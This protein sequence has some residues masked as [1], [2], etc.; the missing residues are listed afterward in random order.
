MT[1]EEL[2]QALLEGEEVT[3]PSREGTGNGQTELSYTLSTM[4]TAETHGDPL[5]FGEEEARC[6]SRPV[7]VLPPG[8]SAGPPVSHLSGEG[9]SESPRAVLPGLALGIGVR[10]KAQGMACVQWGPACVGVAWRWA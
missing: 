6:A 7:A 2:S 5:S 9:R 1:E 3:A 4:T 10:E 8:E